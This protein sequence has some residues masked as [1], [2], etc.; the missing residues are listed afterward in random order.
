MILKHSS[1]IATVGK[2]SWVLFSAVRTEQNEGHPS[3]VN[4][5]SDFGLMHKDYLLIHHKPQCL[6]LPY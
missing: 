3:N 1:I 2:V 6:G 5:T 4:K